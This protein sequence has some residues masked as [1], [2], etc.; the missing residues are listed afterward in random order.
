MAPNFQAERTT[1]RAFQGSHYVVYIKF[2][3]DLVQKHSHR[4][5]C[6]AKLG[7]VSE[8]AEGIFSG[9]QILYGLRRALRGKASYHLRRAG[10]GLTLDAAVRKLEQE[11]GCIEPVESLLQRF[12]S[13]E[14]KISEDISTYCA[15]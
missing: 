15:R 1:S 9:D 2:L 3:Q 12:Y 7:G 8:E 4:G 10:V 5:R 13:I 11:F 6:F 14:Q